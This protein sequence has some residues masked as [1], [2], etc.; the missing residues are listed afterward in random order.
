[1]DHHAILP[2]RRC[3]PLLPT[4]HLPHLGIAVS[5]EFATPG[6]SS[7]IAASDPAEPS[8]I[9]MMALQDPV[10]GHELQIILMGPDPEMRDARESLLNRLPIRNENIGRG[11]MKM[12]GY[13]SSKLMLIV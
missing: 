3:V 10:K 5:G 9:V 1:L 2:D 8:L 7:A 13:S 4:T 6:T 11:L 12:H